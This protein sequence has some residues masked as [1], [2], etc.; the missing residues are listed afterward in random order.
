MGKWIYY[1][2]GLVLGGRKL[3]D[4][5]ATF[6]CNLFASLLRTLDTRSRLVELVVLFGILPDASTDT[7]ECDRRQAKQRLPMAAALL[8]GSGGAAPADL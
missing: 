7:V 1:L 4:E 3:S 5:A 6:C 8:D 2:S